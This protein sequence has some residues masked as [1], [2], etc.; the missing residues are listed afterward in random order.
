MW[1]IGQPFYFMQTVQTGCIQTVLDK[2]RFTH[3]RATLWVPREYAELIGFQNISFHK[4][5]YMYCPISNDWDEIWMMINS[6]QVIILD[7]KIEMLK[8][9]K[10]MKLSQLA[11][12]PINNK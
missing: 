5:K 12:N 1:C 11:T 2:G 10:E 4:N 9:R 3:Y 8:A 6:A 7:M